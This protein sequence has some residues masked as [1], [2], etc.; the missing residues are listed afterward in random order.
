MEHEIG[1]AELAFVRAT[2]KHGRSHDITLFIFKNDYLALIRKPMFD[3]PIYRAPSGGLEPEE[4]FEEGAKRESLEETGLEIKLENY[5][6]RIHVRFTGGEDY[7]NWTSHVFKARAIG[8]E[9]KPQNTSEIAE[10]RYGT[11]EELQGPVRQALLGSGRRLLAYRVAL[12]D[13]AVDVLQGM[14][15]QCLPR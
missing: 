12:T 11:I 5:L 1:Q 2:Q 15:G 6:L 9:L 13:L 4:S 8:G 7:L 3:R 10:A 14:T